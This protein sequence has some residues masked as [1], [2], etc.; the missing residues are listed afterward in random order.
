MFNPKELQKGN[1][2]SYVNEIFIIDSIDP[3]SGRTDVTLN[4][5]FMNSL[6]NEVTTT[7]GKVESIKLSEKFLKQFGFTFWQDQK[8]DVFFEHRDFNY[9]AIVRSKLGFYKY[10]GKCNARINYVHEFQNIWPL[11]TKTELDTNKLLKIKL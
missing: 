8:G 5:L 11:L 9:F 10:L 3:N 1:L 6:R 2:V 4:S 7:I